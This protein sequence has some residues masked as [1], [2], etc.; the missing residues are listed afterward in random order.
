MAYAYFGNIVNNECR[1]FHGRVYL[2]LV[3][4]FQ[5]L[6]VLLVLL[7]MNECLFWKYSKQ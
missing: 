4:V 6:V 1:I 7:V 2:V 5:W 3:C